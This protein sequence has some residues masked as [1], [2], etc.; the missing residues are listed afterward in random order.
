M[1]A[2]NLAAPSA[3]LV[4]RAESMFSFVKDVNESGGADTRST[5]Q[6]TQACRK[7]RSQIKL[8]Q[9]P[10]GSRCRWK[11]FHVLFSKERVNAIYTY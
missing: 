7:A 11:K 8:G 4:G 2:L 3:S 9:G 6:L 1:E 5:V 10:M